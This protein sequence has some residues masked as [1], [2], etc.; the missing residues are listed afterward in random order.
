MLSRSP[1]FVALCL[2]VE[3]VSCVGPALAQ[4]DSTA[5][6]TLYVSPTGNDDWAGSSSAANAKLGDGPLATLDGARRRVASTRKSSPRSPIRVVF[7][8]GRY[9]MQ[10]P[11]TFGPTDSGTEE[12]PIR[13]VASKGAK[14]IFTG[15]KL[16]GGWKAEANGLW[17]VEIP[18]VK[19]GSWYFEQL[20]VN[21]RRAIRARSPNRFFEYMRDVE[22][23]PADETVPSESSKRAVQRTTTSSSVL[24][25]LDSLSPSELKDVQLMS[26]HKWDNTKR[27]IDS[28]DLKSRWI[29]CSGDAMK[30]WNPWD[31]KTAFY[32]ENYAAALDAPGEWF[33]SRQGKLSYRPRVGDEISNLE[34][35]AP[36]AQQAILIQGDI[37][38]ESNVEHL[39]FDRLS[40]QNFGWTTPVTGFGPVQAAASIDAVVQIDGAKHIHFNECEIASTG[41]YGIWFR[42][43]C[44]DSS[45]RHCYLHDLGAGGVRVGDLRHSD[46]PADRTSE[47]VIDNNIIRDG[48]HVFPCAVGVWIGHSGD[49]RV[50]H[51]EIA[52]LQY[53]GISVGWK[54][55]YDPSHAQR[56]TIEFNHIHHIGKGT[57]SDMGAVYTLGL[58]HG[59]TINHNLIHD[60]QSFSYGGWGLYND[61]G[62]TGI[63]ME[64]NL[65]YNTQSGGYHQHYGRENIIRNNIFANG[66]EQQLQ[67]SRAEQH[68][69]FTFQKNIVYFTRGDLLAG[70]WKENTFEMDQNL[71]WNPTS[72]TFSFAGQSFAQW[73]QSGK[74]IHSAI[75]DPLFRNAS[76]NDFALSP[77]S[78]AFK[79]GFQSFDYSKVGV[80]GDSSWIS[81]AKNHVIAPI[82]PAPPIPPHE[83]SQDFER[84][85][86]GPLSPFA[87][88]VFEA[89]PN[90]LSVTDEVSFDSKRSFKVS[91]GPTFTRSFSPFF[92]FRPMHHGGLTTFSFDVYVKPK[93][94]MQH[95]WRDSGDKYR[96]G[97]TLQVRDGTIQFHDQKIDL[98]YEKWVSIEVSCKT[99]GDC[100]GKWRLRLTVDGETTQ[101]FDELPIADPNWTNLD[102]LGF[103]SHAQ[104][105]TVYYLD[106]LRLENTKSQLP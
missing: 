25:P 86:I 24:E 101:T 106:N 31:D 29:E 89:S 96:V 42:R 82:E 72:D 65:V 28:I 35:V 34:A 54:W 90:G 33:L 21:G 51:N 100:N 20:W 78:P 22:E 57:L 45:I 14:P 18:E 81:L 5:E 26:F 71:F 95:E 40:F 50:T 73:Q 56:N 8:D 66:V 9:P 58:S 97:P 80:Y 47:V 83:F 75:A 4:S 2:V 102:W 53:T 7:A 91:D 67:R 74:D 92:N 69:S 99:G 84:R 104:Q 1:L 30:S 85:A 79:L 60:V 98:P 3:F 6:I 27:F 63:T 41:I 49:N 36:L 38:R 87:S 64:N 37:Q 43:A 10:T 11:V 76:A 13:Y 12:A 32:V 16:I 77:Q 61:E 93:A 17:S 48:G 52:D 15:G 46:S 39:S 55:G 19:A 103:A 105:E 23:S 88:V 68:K 62:S 44:K 94:I 59:T 70:N